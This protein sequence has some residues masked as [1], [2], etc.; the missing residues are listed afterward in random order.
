M[1][2]FSKIDKAN[3]IGLIVRGH[4]DYV[5]RGG[6]I[7]CSAVSAVSQCCLNGCITYGKNV[8]IKFCKPISL[9]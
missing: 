1:I 7:V 2:C 6:D 4:A 5:K 3:R 9:S 8:D